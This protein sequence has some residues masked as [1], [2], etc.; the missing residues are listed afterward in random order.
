MDDIHHQRREQRQQQPEQHASPPG[1]A[2]S[3]GVTGDAA[4]T[5]VLTEKEE[6]LKRQVC[7]G[8]RSGPRSLGAQQHDTCAKAVHVH[9]A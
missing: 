3:S 2:V 4:A 7:A 9:F 8:G 5:K 1:A 6:F